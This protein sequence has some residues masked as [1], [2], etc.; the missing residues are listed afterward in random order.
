M[1]LEVLYQ[2][3]DLFVVNKPAGLLSVPGRGADKFDSVATRAQQMTG[4]ALVVHRLDCHTSG[5]MLM[6]RGKAAQVELSRQFHDRETEKDYIAVVE[7]IVLDEQ[8]VIDLPMRCD[9]D[10][11]PR[12]IIDF[13][14]GKQAVTRWKK[15]SVQNHTTRLLLQPVT[16]RSHQLRVH[17]Q[18]MG[19]AIVGDTLYGGGQALAQPRMLLHAQTLRF[20]HPQTGERMCVESVCEF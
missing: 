1:K 6:A 17:C 20:T 12:Q 9:I 13:E 8:G 11:R 4:D 3:S 18:S 19:H 7:G 2:D 5:V 16:G 15:L 10:N 14:H